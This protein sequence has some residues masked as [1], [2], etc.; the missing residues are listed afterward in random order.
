MP[1]RKKPVAKKVRTTPRHYNDTDR[2]EAILAYVLHGSAEKASKGR[3]YA[4]IHHMSMCEVIQ[5]VVC[6][7][8]YL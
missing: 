1:R 7:P 5:C 6:V 4:R 2:K 8:V 3:K